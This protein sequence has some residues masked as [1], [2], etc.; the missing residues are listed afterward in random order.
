VGALIDINLLS[1]SINQYV[2]PAGIVEN[3]LVSDLGVIQAA[4]IP[5]SREIYGNHSLYTSLDSRVKVELESH[6]PMQRNLIIQD[7]KETVD[8]AIAEVFF[9]SELK[10][11]FTFDDS[12]VLIERGLI[13]NLYVGNYPLIRKHG[14][15]KQFNKLLTAYD[16]RFYR[17]HLYIT[18]RKY[19]STTDKWGFVK[20]RVTIAPNDYWN[21]SLRFLSEV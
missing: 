16:L 3:R 20:E 14:R 15:R 13:E 19:K 7:E 8:N 4:N 9:E 18:R 21:F 5:R 17:F 6:L 1:Q 2:V 12:G 10:A 11:S